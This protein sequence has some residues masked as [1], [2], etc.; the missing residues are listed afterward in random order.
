MTKLDAIPQFSSRDPLQR[1]FWSERFEQ[2]F[3]PWDSVCVAALSGVQHAGADPDPWLWQQLR[4]GLPVGG[5][6]ECHCHRF[7]RRWAELSP[8]GAA[9]AGFFF[10]D[11]APKGPLFGISRPELER[12]LH[13][14]FE[15]VGEQHVSDSIPVF[16]GKERWLEW[17]RRA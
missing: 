7:F 12:L 10:F 2:D 16:A 4:S 15:L 9:M 5:R 8:P 3:S 1:D 11:D 17:R 13:A 6:L 14:D